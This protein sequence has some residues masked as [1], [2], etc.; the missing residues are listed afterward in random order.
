[1]TMSSQ[2]RV[3]GLGPR[4]KRK[5]GRKRQW[6]P[7]TTFS[8]PFSPK[9]MAMARSKAR[10]AWICTGQSRELGDKEYA[11][12][13]A[14]QSA[15]SRGRSTVTTSHVVSKSLASQMT[16]VTELGGKEYEPIT[17]YKLA[18]TT[19]ASRDKS[20]QRSKATRLEAKKG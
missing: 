7:V 16:A 12:L 2:G 1:M 14:E 9:V 5:E 6:H 11:P 10:Q 20:A 13:A 3:Q 19:S 18:A 8:R 17:P 4:R 15:A